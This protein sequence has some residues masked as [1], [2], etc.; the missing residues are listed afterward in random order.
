MAAK[1]LLPSQ[2]DLPRSRPFTPNTIEKLGRSLS[3][4]IWYA[5]RSIRNVGHPFRRNNIPGVRVAH[6]R[7]GC[8]SPVLVRSYC[9]QGRIRPL[10]MNNSTNSVVEDSASIS[11]DQSFSLSKGMNCRLCSQERQR[12]ALALYGKTVELR[13]HTQPPTYPSLS[14]TISPMT[15]LASEKPI[16]YEEVVEGEAKLSDHLS[17]EGMGSKAP[18]IQHESVR[19]NVPRVELKDSLPRIFTTRAPMSWQNPGVL[20]LPRPF[21]VNDTEDRIEPVD[22][23]PST[24]PYTLAIVKDR[25]ARGIRAPLFEKMEWNGVEQRRRAET[26]EP[27]PQQLAPTHRSAMRRQHLP[28]LEWPLAR[29]RLEPDRYQM[30]FC[31]RLS[32]P[33]V[34]RVMLPSSQGCH[35]MS[36]PHQRESSS[37]CG[38]IHFA[39]SIMS[40]EDSCPISNCPSVYGSGYPILGIFGQFLFVLL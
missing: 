23:A 27:P 11:S 2:T 16:E 1:D 37:G 22:I 30:H 13:P 36:L 20:C 25:T 4:T 18:R 21:I 33:I 5:W 29:T 19:P 35:Y 3:T 40:D 24:S 6:F 32:R 10:P 9:S 14:E 12:E 17:G 34:H 38:S 7:S 28:P 39:C 8:A 15:S 31:E 26:L